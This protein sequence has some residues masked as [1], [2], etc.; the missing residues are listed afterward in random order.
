MPVV[1][2]KTQSSD[3]DAAAEELQLRLWHEKSF[4]E[5]FRLLGELCEST[6][7]LARVGLRKRYPEAD[8]HGIRMRLAAMSLDR[9]TMLR[10]YGWDP[11]E[12]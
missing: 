5:R 12:H 3:T 1:N 8:E 11:L 2:H 4:A 7:Y 6:R 10:C 9:E